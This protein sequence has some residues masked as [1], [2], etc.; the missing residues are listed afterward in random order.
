MPICSGS[1]Q[2]EVWW[3]WGRLDKGQMAQAFNVGAVFQSLLQSGEF[4]LSYQP[5]P[6]SVAIVAEYQVGS[7]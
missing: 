3:G 4:Q 7:E 6:G 5:V 2:E 1:G